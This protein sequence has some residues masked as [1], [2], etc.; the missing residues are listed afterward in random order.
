MGGSS[1]PI[2]TDEAPADVRHRQGARYD[3]TPVERAGRQ[4]GREAGRTASSLRVQYVSERLGRTGGDSQG[5]CTV[6]QLPGAC[7][8]VQP[9]LD[10][11]HD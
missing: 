7:L 11:R 8:P 1:W 2:I 3:P 9:Q 10:E 6:K 5:F 4:V